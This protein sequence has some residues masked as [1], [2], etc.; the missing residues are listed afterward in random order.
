MHALSRRIEFFHLAPHPL[1]PFSDQ[2]D[3]T[4]HAFAGTRGN[5]LD[6]VE[7]RHVIVIATEQQNAAPQREQA[8]K[9]VAAPERVVPGLF[10]DQVLG[11]LSP[12]DEP[13]NMRIDAGIRIGPQELNRNAIL[14]LRPR[15]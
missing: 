15:G 11:V 10:R 13:G 12:D 7:E 2:H 1:T 4:R 3:V 6:V 8:F 14:A 9:R 5:M